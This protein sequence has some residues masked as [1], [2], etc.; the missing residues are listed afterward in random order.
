M[1]VLVNVIGSS[2]GDEFPVSRF[3][4]DFVLITLRSFWRIVGDEEGTACEE[5]KQKYAHNLT[6]LSR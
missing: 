3:E 2:V 5:K 4:S 1:N 6:D